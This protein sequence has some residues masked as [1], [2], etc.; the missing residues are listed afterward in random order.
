MNGECSG[1][2]TPL[3]QASLSVAQS[4]SGITVDNCVNYGGLVQ[5]EEGGRGRS[6]SIYSLSD[7]KGKRNVHGTAFSTLET[8]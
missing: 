8:F 7:H 2:T 5:D 4:D 3:N 6:N 1:E